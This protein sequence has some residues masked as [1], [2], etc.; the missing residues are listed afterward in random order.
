MLLDP[1]FQLAKKHGQVEV[2]YR[3]PNLRPK[4]KE[5]FHHDENRQSFRQAFCHLLEQRCS[6]DKVYLMTC[7]TDIFLVFFEGYRIIASEWHVTKKYVKR[8]LAQYRT[9]PRK[10]RTY[11]PEIRTAS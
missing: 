1:P 11:V 2:E 10:V 3:N 6:A 9:P 7:A 8:E 4:A 5:D